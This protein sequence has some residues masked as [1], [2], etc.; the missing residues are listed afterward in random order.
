M[1][2]PAFEGKSG[3]RLTVA[4][5]LSMPDETLGEF[6]YPKNKA[7]TKHKWY[8]RGQVLLFG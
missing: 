4:F 2:I 1:S 6:R 3:R 7:L 8:E 5:K